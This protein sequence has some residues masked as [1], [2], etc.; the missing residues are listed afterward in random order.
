MNI[1]S[2]YITL[3]HLLDTVGVAIHAVSI[4]VTCIFDSGLKIITIDKI[5]TKY[6]LFYF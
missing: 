3:F 6:D 4:D 5:S 1:I 2:E